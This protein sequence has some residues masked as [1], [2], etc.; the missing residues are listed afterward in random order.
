VFGVVSIFIWA[1]YAQLALALPL[2]ATEILPEPK[3]V[4]LIWA[5]NSLIVISLQG[6]ITKRII[7]CLHPLTALGFGVLIVGLG[8]GSLYFSSSFIH[9][10]I[11]G[12]I[13]VVGEML[14]LPTIDS[15]VSQLSKAELIGL[16]FALATVVSGIG[17]AGGKFVGS[18]L[19]EI[20]KEIKYVPWFAYGVMGIILFLIVLMLKRWKPLTI[21][22]QNAA[23]KE[24]KPKN[25][26]KVPIGPTQHQSHPF[27]DWVPEMVF[28]KKTNTE[29]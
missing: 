22:L 23:K 15:T 6:L 29:K 1:L 5:I 7:D 2:R 19:L 27:N 25:T 28:R 14:I 4:A 20:G 24:N 3:N 8:V 26:P 17:E 11:S 12:A 13:F 16:F 10:V 18:N 21:S 9:L